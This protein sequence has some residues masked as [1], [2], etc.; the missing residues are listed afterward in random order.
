AGVIANNS[1]F[2]VT[3]TKQILNAIA[4]GTE[5]ETPDIRRLRIQGF[6]EQDIVEGVAAFKEKRAP[7]Y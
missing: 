7:R 6:H 4:E 2:A 5:Q 3:A 1:P